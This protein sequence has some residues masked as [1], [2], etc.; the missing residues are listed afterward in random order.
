MLASSLTAQRL[1]ARNQVRMEAMVLSLPSPWVHTVAA[2]GGG[3]IDIPQILMVVLAVVALTAVMLSTRRRVRDSV[4]QPSHTAREQFAQLK[5][6]TKAV[7]DVEQVMLELDQLSRQIHGRL[8]TKLARLEVVIRD[9]DARIA[10]LTRLLQQADGGPRVEI[11]LDEEKP[12]EPSTCEPLQEESNRH[13]AV[14]RLVDNGSSPLEIAKR[15]GRPVGEVELI[16][17]LR[18]TQEKSPAASHPSAPAGPPSRQ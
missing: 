10:K 1:L 5:E 14:F 13:S 11:T 2:G 3:K 8:D 6:Q 4:R 18:Q 9:A 17:A 15:L 7:R 12:Y 16:L